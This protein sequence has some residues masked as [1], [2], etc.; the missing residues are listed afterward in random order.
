[1]AGLKKYDV[2]AELS[3]H[4]ISVPQ[5]EESQEIC[6]VPYNDYRVFLQEYAVLPAPEALKEQ[7]AQ[8]QAATEAAKKAA[9]HPGCESIFEF[10][11]KTTPN[12]PGSLS[13]TYGAAVLPDG[14][15][16]GTHYGLWNYTE[17]QR[18]GL[19]I[20]WKEPL[21]VLGKDVETNTLLV[22]PKSS[23]TTQ[24]CVCAQLNCLV[25]PENWPDIV[26]AKTRYRQELR[27]AHYKLWNQNGEQMLQLDFLQDEPIP[28]PAP[29]Q[30]A[31]L[32]T[33]TPQGNRL[34]AG[35]VIVKK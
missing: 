33:P 8:E 19:G 11:Q 23:F 7:F 26:L 14:V 6:F 15:R 3:R 32:Y 5:K 20:A 21:F 28:P 1:L 27:S 2:L 9:K 10:A 30:I 17:G 29:G 18:H 24:S 12:T 35:A 16:V 13:L 31:A 22:G 25:P 4:A 34:L